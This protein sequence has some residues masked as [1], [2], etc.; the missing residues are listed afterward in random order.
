MFDK[1]AMKRCHQVLCEVLATLSDVA[2]EIYLVGGWA[3]FIRQLEQTACMNL[4]NLLDHIF[5]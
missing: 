2:A 1:Q 5:G 3:V 4:P